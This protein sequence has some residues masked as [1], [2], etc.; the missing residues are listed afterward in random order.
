MYLCIKNKSFSHFF[1]S[2]LPVFLIAVVAISFAVFDNALAVVGTSRV[3]SYQGRLTDASGN[4]LGGAG[5][6]YYFC[7]SIYDASS[8]GT[9]LWP[10]A[11]PTATSIS[12]KNGV[13]NVDVGS[14]VDDLSILNFYSNDSPY[15]QVEVSATNGTCGGAPF[16]TLSPRQRID[17]VPFARVANDVYGSLLKTDNAASK[18]QI[19]S[20]A[21]V[22]SG[23]ILL[24]LDVKNIADT[25]GSACSPSGSLWYN[26][27]NA[28]VL[29][30]KA[31]VIARVGGATTT[32]TYITQTPNADLVNEQALSV[33]ATGPLKNTT[34]TGVLTV[35]AINLASA[36]EVTGNLP[37]TNLGSGTGASASTFWRGDGTWATPAGGGSTMTTVVTQNASGLGTGANAAVALS[38]LT[39]YKVGL[40]NIPYNIT[41][42]QLA[43]NVGAVTTAG[44]YRICVYNEAGTTKSIDVTDVP[45]AGVN[46]VAVGAVALSPGNY[47][48]A[49][50]CA[51]TCNNTIFMFTSV[52]NTM[53][54]T[55][56]VPAGK[57]VYEGTATM[58]SGTCNATLPAITGVISSTAVVRLDN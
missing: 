21:G 46:T 26:S 11:T 2:T 33:L 53:V 18:V 56:A 50:G 41:V 32:A 19:G 28:E 42:N 13:F 27:S 8:G 45:T 3:I 34:G 49:M 48:I 30:C 14:G 10:V 39:V 36:S 24:G 35:G 51:T 47:Y 20:G 31:G 6:T 57:K 40:F 16:E 38:S 54:N 23:Q 17:A 22:A 1:S 12:V 44:S 5:T 4:P 37:V 43:F 29:I 52:A 9:K 55:S 58:T 7:F 15:M 25:M